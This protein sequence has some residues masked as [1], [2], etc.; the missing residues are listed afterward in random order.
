MRRKLS[1]IAEPSYG[2]KSDKLAMDAVKAGI[3][4]PRPARY[5]IECDDRSVGLW[6]RR[7]A[8]R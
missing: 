2:T 7:S 3:R 4:H 6:L 8:D 5:V 1:G